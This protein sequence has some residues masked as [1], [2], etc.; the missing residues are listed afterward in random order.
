[1][2]T[3]STKDVAVTYPRENPILHLGDETRFPALVFACLSPFFHHGPTVS[4]LILSVSPWW[5]WGCTHRRA[6]SNWLKKSLNRSVFDK[7]KLP[8]HKGEF[9]VL[10][11][12]QCCFLI[13]FS[14]NH[15][16]VS[17]SLLCSHNLR[18][19][20]RL[21]SSVALGWLSAAIQ[22][23]SCLLMSMGRKSD[24]PGLFSEQRKVF[25]KLLTGLEL[26]L[27][28]QN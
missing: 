23:T 14:R 4:A 1:M 11:G 3:D 13:M 12:L 22:F 28:V 17:A 21:T 15:I 5:G 19:I 7:H 25:Q 18:L 2:K 8:A 10:S 24:F 6:N 9:Q 16:C 20:L 27:L 26:C